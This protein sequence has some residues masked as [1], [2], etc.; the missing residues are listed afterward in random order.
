MCA[1]LV[2][3]IELWM[4]GALMTFMVGVS[5]FAL[6]AFVLV[7]LNYMQS[8]DD[9]A[10]EHIIPRAETVEYEIVFESINTPHPMSSKPGAVQD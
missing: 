10:P 4:K 7:A 1:G 6:F 3:S 9:E 8:M 5:S 2:L